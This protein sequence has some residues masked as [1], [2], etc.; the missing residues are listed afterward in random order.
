MWTIVLLCVCGTI[1]SRM[2]FEIICKRYV[3]KDFDFPPECVSHNLLSFIDHTHTSCNNTALCIFY[4]LSGMII[5]DKS[6]SVI[7]NGDKSITYVEFVWAPPTCTGRTH[8]FHAFVYYDGL[9]YQSY[10]THKYRYLPFIS[11]YPCIVFEVDQ[12]YRDLFEKNITTLDAKTFNLLCAPS[13]HPV[14]KQDSAHFRCNRI[15]K[16]PSNPANAQHWRIFLSETLCVG[17]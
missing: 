10:R 11:G 12:Q 1:I 14:T 16:V 2:I 8:C 13:K 9:I 17:N 15:I 5:D 4:I 7:L 6:P 3:T